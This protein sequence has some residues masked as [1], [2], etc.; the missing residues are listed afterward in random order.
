M[1]WKELQ[2]IWHSSLLQICTCSNK[3]VNFWIINKSIHC[4][5]FLAL[6][7]PFLND[8][9][10]KIYLFRMNIFFPWKLFVVSIFR[11]DGNVLFFENW[12]VWFLLK[13]IYFFQ[14]LGTKYAGLSCTHCTQWVLLMYICCRIFQS[15][16]FPKLQ[17]A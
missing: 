6:S 8:I 9:Y 5:I 4:L 11:Y 14:Y 10:Y 17:W 2:A 13:I 3:H 12:T 15:R 1:H 16:F 7:L